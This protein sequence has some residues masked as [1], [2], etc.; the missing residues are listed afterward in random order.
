MKEKDI[1]KL[2]EKRAEN[3]ME[4]FGMKRIPTKKP[5]GFYNRPK[6]K[7]ERMKTFYPKTAEEKEAVAKRIEKLREIAR[8]KDTP[9]LV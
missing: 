7:T 6:V 8:S 5:R 2:E 4:Y 9:I 1:E 3:R